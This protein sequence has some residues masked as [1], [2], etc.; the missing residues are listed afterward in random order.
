MATKKKTKEKP[1]RATQMLV[2]GFDELTR[3][4]LDEICAWA[5][6]KS[7]S[8]MIRIIIG[9]THRSMQEDV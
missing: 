4:R 7:R 6:I 9:A 3:K 2:T 5:N 8:A 1:S